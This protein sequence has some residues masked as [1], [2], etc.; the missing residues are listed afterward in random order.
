MYI[1]NLSFER[2]EFDILV[3]D[4]Y[5]TDASTQIL[6]KFTRCSMD[7]T[8]ISFVGRKVGTSTGEFELK[9]KYI[10][11]FLGEGVL[12]G[13]FTGSLPCRF[14]GYKFRSYNTN[15]LN[16]FIPFKT[17]YYNP[18]DVI[19]DP[20]FGS[21][22]ANNRTLSG[23]DKISKNYLGLSSSL[24]D[25]DFFDFKGFQ[26]PTALCTDVDGDEWAVVTQGFHMDISAS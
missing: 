16:P 22:T 7:P 2:G 18:G 25:R 8:K 26:E 12:D 4:F 9:S 15:S 23:G 21:S 11:L 3:R 17:K 6:E 10:M 24:M 14:E 13:T 5:D 20:P 1:T 19:Y